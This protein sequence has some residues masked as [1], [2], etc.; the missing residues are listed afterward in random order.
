MGWSETHRRWQVLRELEA[1]LSRTDGPLPW[2]QEYADLFGD[3]AAMLAML[4]YR[5]E[6]AR[7]AQVD[8]SLPEHVLDEQRRR[9]DGR[10]AGVR[11]IL[12]RYADAGIA[13]GNAHVAA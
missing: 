8:P 9:I 2:N 7:D 10:F 3:R 11:R 12:Q 13:D 4:R 6:L 1:D 5:W